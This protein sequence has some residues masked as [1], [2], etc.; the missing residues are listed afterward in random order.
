MV[1]ESSPQRAYRAVCPQCGAPVEF[2]SAA[3]LSAVC[4]Y[5]RSTLVRDGEALRRIGQ[6]AELFDDYSPLQLGANGRYQGEPFTLVGRLQ[7]AYPE[8]VWNE[9]HALFDNGKSA[10]LSEDNGAFVLS[11]DVALDTMAGGAALPPLAGLRAGAWL[12]LGGRRWSV[13][14]VT[15]AHV[16]AAQG[17]LP[18]APSPQAAFHVAEL[19]NDAGEVLSIDDGAGPALRAAVGRG[20]RLADLALQ[21]LRVSSD[22]AV[23][24]RAFDCPSCGAAL[25]PKVDQSLSIV[26]GQCHAVVDLSGPPAAPDSRADLGQGLAFQ[27]QQGHPDLEPQLPLGQ[28]GVL[29]L[30]SSTALPWQVV[31]YLERCEL[32]HAGSDDAQAFWREYLLYHRSEGFV[33]LVDA[34]EGWSWMRPLTGVPTLRGEQAQWAGDTYRR[35]WDYEARATYVLGEFYWRLQRDDRQ[36]VTDYIGAGPA[37]T[38]RLSRE[39]AADGREVTWSAGQTLEAAEIAKAF[40]LSLPGTAGGLP[41]DVSPASSLSGRD[42]TSWR[43]IVVLVLIVLLILILVSRCSRDDCDAVA[44]SFGTSSVEYQQCRRS[45]SSWGHGTSGGSWGGYSGGGGG[46]K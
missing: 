2:R 28:T 5:C 41:R 38:K 19:R 1:A 42:G 29:A 37:R 31:G 12:D 6:S 10:W 9:W 24:G 17:E 4:S 18:L 26:C 8:G 11:F 20:V 39:A 7:M 32:P 16:G 22:K 36:H 35:Q 13:A 23:G 15:T 40:K 34:E 30:G 3:S 25:A 43:T 27:A 45:G 33:F 46:H 44:Q 21:G 14:A